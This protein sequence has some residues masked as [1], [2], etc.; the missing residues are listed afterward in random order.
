MAARA[1]LLAEEPGPPHSPVGSETSM[2]SMYA[3]EQV[4]GFAEGYADAD[5]E[6][7]ARA[8]QAAIRAALIQVHNALQ[9]IEA[10]TS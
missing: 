8:R 7:K 2:T 10:A 3:P 5:A 6:I 4:A 1:S 9:T